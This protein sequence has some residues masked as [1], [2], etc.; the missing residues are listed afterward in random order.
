M[1]L[2]KRFMLFAVLLILADGLLAQVTVTRGPYVQQSTTSSIIIHWRTDIA[3]DSKVYYGQSPG[4]MN[5]SVESS[6]LT[7]EHIIKISGLPPSTKYFY[8]IANSDSN[9]FSNNS[10]L[11]FYTNPVEGSADHFRFWVIGDA[12][13]G[14]S[15]QR[16]VR[17]AFFQRMGTTKLDGWL[18][19]GDN[20]YFYGLDSEYQNAVFSNNTYEDILP[21]LVAWAAPGNHDYGQNPNNATPEFLDIFDFPANGEAGGLASGTEKYFSWNY[22]NI[23][24]L[25]L[26]SYGSD[27]SDTGAV[28]QWLNADL[29]QNKSTW[30]IAYFHHPPY[31]KGSHDSDDPNGW[32]PELPRIRN[33]IVKVLEEKGVDL[34]LSGHSHDYER[35][36]LIDGHYGNSTTLHDSMIVDSTSGS[37]PNECAYA[38]DTLGGK[39][40]KGTVYAVV[41]V[42]GKV[43]GTQTDWPHPVMFTSIAN[44]LGSMLL[45]VH[46][47]KLKAT[48]INSLGVS[49]DSF[50]IIKNTAVRKQIIACKD[51]ALMLQT[52]W[53]ENA[54]WFPINMSGE[55]VT[56]YPSSDTLLVATDLINC[57]SDTFE[58]HVVTDTLCAAIGLNENKSSDNIYFIY[59][60]PSSGKVT[61]SSELYC[62]ELN[63]EISDISGKRVCGYK[64]YAGKEFAADLSNLQEGIYFFRITCDKMKNT[65]VLKYILTR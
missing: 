44:E 3:T 33:G 57:L 12:G 65:N 21:H 46:E 52:T 34:V 7:T 1:R 36:F 18:W 58:I 45:E 61:I 55:S 63:V 56:I 16:I 30:I 19:L 37:Y 60:N 42:S 31:T 47:N 8:T 25:Q 49:R 39:G 17:D 14:D 53:H 41:G 26:D 40:N 23:H 38:K 9:L 13:M 15:N 29:A 22:G 50:M 64:F 6:L 32:D 5:D 51:S 24:F 48:F 59:P 35:S 27:V 2:L 62:D 43:S 20:A 11:F 54:N 10:N 4:A 28:A